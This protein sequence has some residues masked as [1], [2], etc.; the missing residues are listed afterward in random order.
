MRRC[1]KNICNSN[2]IFLSIS[3]CMATPS[4]AF[5]TYRPLATE[6]MGHCA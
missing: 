2:E 4:R 5:Q 1:P 3:S 6:I